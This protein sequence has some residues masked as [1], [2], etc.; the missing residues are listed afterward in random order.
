[1]PYQVL[2]RTY[3]PNKFSEVIGQDHIIKTLKN[4][5]KNN[6]V[7]HAYLFAGPRGTGKTTI[8]KIFAKAINCE[9]YISEPCDECDTCLSI[10]RGNCPDVIELDAASN[11][12][13][14]EIRNI[15]NE[16]AYPPAVTKYKV[17]II[18]E[19]HMLTTQ[20]FNALLKTLEEPPEHVVFILA[21]TDPQKVI[22]TVL[23]RCQRFNF[24]KL[25]KYQIVDKMKEILDKENLVY[26]DEALNEIATLADGGM[27]DALSILEEVLSYSDNGV[28][29][30]D[31]EAIF[32]LTS[33]KELVN[34]FVE[35]S[36]G[37]TTKVVGKLKD[38]YKSGRDLKRIATDLLE[39]L[40]DTL[41][42]INSNDDSLLE[43]IDKGEAEIIAQEIPT[44]KLYEDISIF[45]TLLKDMMYSGESLSYIELAFIK[46]DKKAYN[47]I[48]TVEIAKETTTEYKKEEAKKII[49]EDNY[50]IDSLAKILCTAT[51]EQKEKDSI[52]YNRLELYKFDTD[53][54]KYY[55][56]L[57][58]AKMFASTPDALILTG[59]RDIALSINDVD[60]NKELYKFVNNEFGIDKVFIAFDQTLK[61]NL[62]DRFRYYQGNKEFEPVQIK[63]FELEREKTEQEKIDE[64]F[65]SGNK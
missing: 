35:A 25:T 54:R 29:L 64:V 4:S 33:T 32:G 51:K 6:K 52:I 26:E 27:R 36:S 63:K 22:P 14:D 10:S 41:L 9:G 55:E 30:R 23:S 56:L 31:V 8:A 20:A 40:K 44:Q 18:D 1:M 48:K 59:P 12:G 13:V 42:Y 38:M 65:G 49:E 21:T 60:N 39:I 7:A 3:R 5:I 17:Y 15:I 50:D 53:K 57:S 34:L 16:V 37:E 2:Y 19:V 11:N 62:I 46:L 47:P 58:R 45:Q 61:N 28:N 24:S 43:K